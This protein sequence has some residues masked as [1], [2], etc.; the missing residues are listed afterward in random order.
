MW[1]SWDQA[2]LIRTGS[3]EVLIVHAW[4]ALNFNGSNSINQLDTWSTFSLFKN[5]TLCKTLSCCSNIACKIHQGHKTTNKK[6]RI[7][8]TQFYVRWFSRYQGTHAI[9]NW[10][11]RKLSFGFLFFYQFQSHRGQSLCNL[12]KSN[13]R[14]VRHL[15]K[16]INKHCANFIW[17]WSDWESNP[18][19]LS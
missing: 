5:F 4:S 17:L 15:H 6:E 8:A 18:L 1:I 11:N 10:L 3:V 16:R 9:E 12:L 13:L 7:N 2:R 19:A 14:S